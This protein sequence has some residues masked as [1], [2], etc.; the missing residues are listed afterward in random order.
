MSV[1]LIDIYVLSRANS[2]FARTLVEADGF[3]FGLF[4]YVGGLQNV[5]GRVEDDERI[6]G[7]VGLPSLRLAMRKFQGMKIG[8]CSKLQ[9]TIICCSS[10]SP[11][12]TACSFACGRP[13]RMSRIGNSDQEAPT[14]AASSG[15]SAIGG[16]KSA[17]QRSNGRVFRTTSCSWLLCVERRSSEHGTLD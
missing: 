14:D 5:V 15:G 10:H 7:Y 4:V 17:A 16:G 9:R 8:A 1:W 12:V 2:K 13:G 3:E 11:C 6:S